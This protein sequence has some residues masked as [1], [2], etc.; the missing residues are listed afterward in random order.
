MTRAKVF[1]ETEQGEIDLFD[2]EVSTVF[3][4]CFFLYLS[5]ANKKL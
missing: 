5:A 4:I 2:I 3:L 1:Q